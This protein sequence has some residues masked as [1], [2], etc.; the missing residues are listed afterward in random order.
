M[1]LDPVTG[2]HLTYCTN[3][4]PGGNWEDSRQ[5]LETHLPALKKN[6]SPDKAMGI[7]LRLSAV[8]AEELVSGDSLQDF[9][10]WLQ[11]E[12][13]YV[14]TINGFPYGNFHRERVKDLVYSPDWRTEDR[15]RYTRILIQILAKLLPEDME[16]GISTS[17]VSYKRW[18]TQPSLREEA[19]RTG[20]RNLAALAYEM[21]QILDRGGSELH[22]DIEPE[23]DCLIENSAETI[24][25]FEK[26]LLP[27]GSA[28]LSDR[29]GIGFGEAVE[30][31]RRHIRVCYDTCH[32]AVEYEE[33]RSAIYSLQEA[34]IRIGKTQVSSALK[35]DLKNPDRT[36]KQIADAL[37][38][39]DEPVYLHQVVERRSSGELFRYRDLPDALPEIYNEQA[40][41]WRIHFHVPIFVDR[42]DFL[43]S[44]QDEIVQSIELLSAE[45]D[46]R[47]FEVETYTWEVLPKPLKTDMTNS[48]QRELEWVLE[49]FDGR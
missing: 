27:V 34:D 39:F 28:S 32:F 11:Q 38:Q 45:T 18:L 30:I 49:I 46:C 15:V 17:P 43:H 6:L 22:L 26:Y 25:F 42:F 33:P 21:H 44:T 24:E 1:N 5:Q 2:I 16:G 47:H 19:F 48:I 3:I 29:F 20:S 7:G 31:I 8:A 41:E 12:G 13:L 23:P 14:F 10:E 37:Q 4:H 9:R 36:R 35:V 40:E